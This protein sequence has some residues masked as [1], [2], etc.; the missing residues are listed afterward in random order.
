M[1]NIRRTKQFIC[2]GYF[3]A[4][5]G[6]RRSPGRPPSPP[7]ELNAPTWNHAYAAFYAR[8]GGGRTLASFGNSLKNTRDSFDGWL[9]SGRVGWR[10][11]KKSQ[12]PKTL[13][14]LEQQ[15]LSELSTHPRE[16]VWSLVEPF[17]D[18]RVAAIPSSVLSDLVNDG[19]DREAL[20]TRTE[21]GRHVYVSTRVERDPALRAD[22]LRIHGYVCAACSFDFEKAYGSRGKNYAEVHHLI[23]L[24]QSGDEL[25]ETDP[26]K[27]MIVLCSNCHRMAHRRRNMVLSLAE[28]RGKLARARSS[29][30][31]RIPKAEKIM[32][33]C[34]IRSLATNF[35]AR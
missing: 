13:S 15:V 33:L 24:S 18:P 12:N 5:Y 29:L 6:D 1:A 21:G 10:Q 16:A 22:A 25:R 2:A 4:A 17:A 8:L 32:G 3:L 19:E 14:R 23:R 28:L 30:K 11:R 35:M 34:P 7:T 27:D 9:K 26:A 20:R 31:Q